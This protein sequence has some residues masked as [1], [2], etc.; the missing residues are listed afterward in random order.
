MLG[1]KNP[2]T[3]SNLIL[4]TLTIV[5]SLSQEKCDIFQVVQEMK[6]LE[7]LSQH[8]DSL[9][10]LAVSNTSAVATNTFLEEDHNQLFPSELVVKFL[11]QTGFDP[12][13]RNSDRETPLHVAAKK[14]G[15]EIDS[16][17]NFAK[18]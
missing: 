17:L 1:F 3:Y 14:V 7:P 4:I 11:L 5:E 15:L 13:S 10:H 12:N 18:F 9:L 8:Q 16:H 6:H 2:K